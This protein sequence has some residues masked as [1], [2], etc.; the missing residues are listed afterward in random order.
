MYIY[1]YNVSRIHFY[2]KCAYITL[3]D[4]S[5]IYLNE[6]ESFIL[7]EILV[8]TNKYEYEK[9]IIHLDSKLEI[10]NFQES[11]ELIEKILVS[12]TS[13]LKKG[14]Y[15]NKNLSKFEITGQYN[16]CYPEFIQISLTNNCNHK[17]VHCYKGETKKIYSLKLEDVKKLLC[18]IKGKV[19]FIQ[20]TGGEPLLYDGLKKI[21]DEFKGDFTFTITTSAFITLTEKRI[22]ILKSFDVVQVSLYGM[23]HEEHHNFSNTKGSFEVVVKNIKKMILENINITISTI[24]TPINIRNIDKFIDKCIDMKISSIMFG[25]IIGIGN[26]KTLK[27]MILT[28]E[29]EKFLENQL[30]VYKI[31]Y[32]RKIEILTWDKYEPNNVFDNYIFKCGGGK[33]NLAINEQG[34]ILPC[35]LVNSDIFKMGLIYNMDYIKIFEE[36]DYNLKLYNLWN[37]RVHPSYSLTHICKKIALGDKL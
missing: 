20:F 27:N 29:Q 11:K 7:N 13:I 26:G 18:H 4:D 17:C 9:L 8:N 21:I 37:E 2:H 16:K 35:S 28:D 15:I 22:D 23:K 36:H 10:N 33:L 31:K 19:K 14:N 12:L 3:N 5:S 34:V 30:Q 6:L 25:K 24:I 1:L 32:L